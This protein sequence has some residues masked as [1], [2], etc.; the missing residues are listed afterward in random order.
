MIKKIVISVCLL[1]LFLHGTGTAQNRRIRES[2]VRERRSETSARS[3]PRDLYVPIM[4]PANATGPLAGTVVLRGRPY[5]PSMRP[6]A[7][8][9]VSTEVSAL[10][11]ELVS[12]RAEV[13]TLKSQVEK[14]QKTVDELKPVP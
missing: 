11:V 4:T 7:S 1:A 2:Y 8:V 3:G 14:L 9:A 12:L 5:N 13:I 10:R 6:T